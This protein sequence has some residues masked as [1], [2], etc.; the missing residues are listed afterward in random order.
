MN[1]PPKVTVLISGRGSNLSALHENAKGYQ[2]SAVVSNNV[3][4]AGLEWAQQR[5]IPTY[6][7]QR[8]LFPSLVEFK[9]A[10]LQK[11]CETSPDIVALAG[12]MV[13]L[14][15]EFVERFTGRLINIHPS[16]LPK[17][18]G[19]HTHQR[20]LDAG[21][22][23]HGATVHFV[24]TGVDTG[25][26]IAQGSVPVYRDDSPETL[27]DRTLKVEHTIYPWVVQHLATGEIKLTARG[28]V[29]SDRVRSEALQ[30]KFSLIEQGE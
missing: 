6:T 7:V 17:Y 18:P 27:A 19:L 13:V 8:N 1:K 21:E 22:A 14:Q 2:V 10:V 12:F 15:H 29:Y 11:V 26:I 5:G 23:E 9:A 16:I 25:P 28:V 4:A 20:A 3:E 24:A 30:R